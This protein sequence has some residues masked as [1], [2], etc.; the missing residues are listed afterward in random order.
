[1]L[2]LA[3]CVDTG[4]CVRSRE[5]ERKIRS[6]LDAVKGGWRAQTELDRVKQ[7]PWCY[8]GLA[9]AEVEM[10]FAVWIARSN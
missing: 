1:M 6:W 9:K 2:G 3:S 7:K 4:G 8:C 5:G 10:Y